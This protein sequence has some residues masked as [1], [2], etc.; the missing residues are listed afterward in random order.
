M[1]KS[2]PSERHVH[3]YVSTWYVARLKVAN[4]QAYL[5]AAAAASCADL[6]VDALVGVVTVVAV[7]GASFLQR[8]TLSFLFKAGRGRL[9]K[10]KFAHFCLRR[11][12]TTATTTPRGPL[13]MLQK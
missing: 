5:S 9:S 10:K 8:Q 6:D 7:T 2:I 11:R 3:S 12:T 4:F 1:C 13:L